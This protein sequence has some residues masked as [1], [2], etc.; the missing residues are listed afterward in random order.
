MERM[1]MSFQLSGAD[2]PALDFALADCVTDNPKH[3]HTKQPFYLLTVHRSAVGDDS[4]AAL[5]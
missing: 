4:A 5:S 3:K 1:Y 2:N